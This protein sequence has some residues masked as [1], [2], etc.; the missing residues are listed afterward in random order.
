MTKGKP[1]DCKMCFQL[2]ENKLK[3]NTPKLASKVIRIVKVENW[4][5][6]SLN[7]II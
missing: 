7:D 4:L 3:K 1:N 6:V 2:K 5:T